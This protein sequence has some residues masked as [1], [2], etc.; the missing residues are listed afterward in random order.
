MPAL[1][2]EVRPHAGSVTAFLGGGIMRKRTTPVAAAV[3][4]AGA[5]M[6]PKNWARLRV[7]NK[8][9]FFSQELVA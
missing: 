4:A 6:H 2:P 3:L 8:T 7:G 5:V 9:L 1:R